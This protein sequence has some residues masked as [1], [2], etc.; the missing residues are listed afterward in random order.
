MRK[1]EWLKKRI[2]PLSDLMKVRSVLEEMGLHTV[3]DEARCPNLGECFSQGT[4]TFL[5]LGDVCTRNCGFCAVKHG[6]PLPPSE[7]E[8]WKVALAVRNLNLQY[9]V[10]TSV[11]RD[12]LPDGGAYHFARTIRSI[13]ALNPKIKIEV[14]IPDFQGN[15]SSLEIVLSEGPEVINHNVE[16]VAR[17]Y[18]RVRPQASFGRSMELLKRVKEWNERILTKS[19]FMVGLGE[20]HEEVL[21]L[22]RQLR[23]I[24]CD[25]LTIGQYLQP[26]TDRLPVERYIPP[27]EFEEFKK[28]GEEIGFKAVASGP[29]VRSSFHAFRMFESQRIHL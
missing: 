22:M 18:P 10:I 15:P 12:D 11:T 1:P 23:E 26:R 4:A 25:F 27:E 7:E 29:F 17:L 20:T 24:G 21:A 14:L 2:P 5:I 3:C 28:I 6:V 19:G 13:H 8:P 16:T 9:V